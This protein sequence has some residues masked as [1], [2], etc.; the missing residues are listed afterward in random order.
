[1]MDHYTNMY[2]QLIHHPETLGPVQS[3]MELVVSLFLFKNE[4]AASAVQFFR[5]YSHTAT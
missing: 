4:K 3:F 5:R 2:P 1:M